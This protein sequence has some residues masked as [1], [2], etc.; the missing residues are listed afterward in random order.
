MS[1]RNYGWSLFGLAAP[2]AT[3]AACVP[4]LI[5]R[6]G[7]ER[8]GLLSLAWALIGLSGVFDLGIGRAATR[9]VAGALGRGDLVLVAAVARTAIL[10]STGAGVLAM[11]A[12]SLLGLLH[13]SDL[14]HYS[15]ALE[16][17]V[18]DAFKLICVAVP[19]QTIAASYRG[20]SEGLGHFRAIGLIRAMIGISTFL[21]PV[22]VTFQTQSLTWLVAALLVSRIVALV[23]FRLAALRSMRSDGITAPGNTTSVQQSIVPVLLRFGGW[24]TVSMVAHPILMQADRFFIGALISATAVTAYALP[25]EVVIQ[26]LVIVTAIS[27]VLFPRLA[28]AVHRDPQ[29]AAGIFRRAFALM[30]GSMLLI[31]VLLYVWIGDLLAL[32]VH[33]AASPESTRIGRILVLGLLPYSAAGAYVSLAHARN[34]PDITGILHVLELPTFLLA[35]HFSVLHHGVEGAAWTWVARVTFDAAALSLWCTL[36]PQVR[37][38]E[39]LS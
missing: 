2:A 28:T 30:A 38:E 33:A 1:L 32:W 34:R 11:L 26:S 5:E 7:A 12:L 18:R 39:A 4:I 36:R 15:P 10:I 23:L 37:P 31:A 29:A 19:L 6:V 22:A 8:F 20:V 14:V 16:G 13:L 27:N 17:E 9:L 25:Y 3:A 21:G 35:M 24:H